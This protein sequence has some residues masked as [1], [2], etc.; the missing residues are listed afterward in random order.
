[1]KKR[2][3]IIGTLLSLLPFGKPLVIG[4]DVALTS[5]AVMFSVPQ[6]AN[7]ESAWSYNRSGLSKREI[8]DYH[9]AIYD[10]TKAIGID[11]YNHVFYNNRAV[12]KRKLGDNYGAIYDYTKAIELNPNNF[13][14]YKN[15]GI[16]K[17]FMGDLQGA[18]SDWKISSRLGDR[19]STQWVEKDCL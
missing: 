4:T 16:A 3:A 15:R 2:T 10:Y 17:E 12:A 18:C 7:A 1:M 19:E 8:G 5:M 14:A 13:A 9:G 6:R 11:P